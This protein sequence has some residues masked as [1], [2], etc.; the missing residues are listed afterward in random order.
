[1]PIPVAALSEAWVCGRSLARDCGFESHR[2]HGC[3]SVVSVVCFLV[4]VSVSGRSLV[5]RSPTAC[6]A[7]ECDRE[8]S[9]MRRPWPT[10]GLMRRGKRNS[11]HTVH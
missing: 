7:S 11:I 6:D 2:G 10:G 8:A 3:L 4:E 1:M 5:Q 9:K